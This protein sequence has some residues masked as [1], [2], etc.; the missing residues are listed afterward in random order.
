MMEKLETCGAT[1]HSGNEVF[2]NGLS[3]RNALRANI[4]NNRAN[5]SFSPERHPCL[6]LRS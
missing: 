4:T 1:N 3:T 2:G 5:H 6:S